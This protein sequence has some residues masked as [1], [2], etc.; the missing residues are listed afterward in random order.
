MIML[1]LTDWYASLGQGENSVSIWTFWVKNRPQTPVNVS[2]LP[3]VYRFCSARPI[4]P[5]RK[6]GSPKNAAESACITKTCL[7]KYSENFTTKKWKFSDK[8]F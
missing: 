4:H 5:D 6:N 1:F 8:K 7:V 2:Y 3:K